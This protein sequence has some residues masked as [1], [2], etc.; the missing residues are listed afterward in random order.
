M[1]P[2]PA[3]APVVTLVSNTGSRTMPD[4]RGLS[5]REATRTLTNLGVSALLSGQGIVLAQNPEP[6]ASF[7]SG[8]ISRLQLG[9]PT[10]LR[11][12]ATQP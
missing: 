11:A 3:H 4:L 2:M 1:V 6:G 5:A 9:R 7:E 10:P 12:S 8:D